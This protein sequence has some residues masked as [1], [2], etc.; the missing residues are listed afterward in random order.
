MRAIDKREYCHDRLG[1]QFADA[2][3]DYDTHRR[4]V[5]L[6]DEFGPLPKN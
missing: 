4:V 6:V 3:S 2:V 5:T 1:S